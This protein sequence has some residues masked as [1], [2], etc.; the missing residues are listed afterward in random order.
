MCGRYKLKKVFVDS[1]IYLLKVSV[2]RRPDIADQ[3][4]NVRLF[5]VE[6]LRELCWLFHEGK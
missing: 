1:C 6:E 2:D 5:F 4:V 3:N